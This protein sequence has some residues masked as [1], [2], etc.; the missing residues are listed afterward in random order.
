MN[1]EKAIIGLEEEN[2]G[3]GKMMRGKNQGKKQG[4]KKVVKRHLS[5]GRQARCVTW[6]TVVF[7]MTND[8]SGG[9]KNEVCSTVLGGKRHRKF[10]A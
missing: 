9:E 8:E 7:R 10:T 1:D 5:G 6:Y 3:V 2:E 4:K